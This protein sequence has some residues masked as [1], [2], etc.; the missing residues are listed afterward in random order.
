MAF[1]EFL[2]LFRGHPAADLPAKSLDQQTT[3]HTD[4]AVNT[5]HGQK[6]AHLI[7]SLVPSEH[8]LI[9]AVDECAIKIEE[10]RWSVISVLIHWVVDPPEAPSLLLNFSISAMLFW[11]SIKAEIMEESWRAVSAFLSRYCL[12]ESE[13]GRALF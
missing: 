7:K 9:D 12:Y 8:M 13:M 5:P 4:A 2:R 11:Y 3:T 6:E 10:Q 1:L